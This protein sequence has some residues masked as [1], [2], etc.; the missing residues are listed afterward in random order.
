MEEV[1]TAVQIKTFK[2]SVRLVMDELEALLLKKQADYGHENI[3]DFGELGCLIRS[4]DKISRL[5]N[6]ML[7]KKSPENETLDDSWIDLANYAIIALM[8]RRNIFHKK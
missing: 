2:E 4:N 1:T 3:T 7:K 5:K 6:L 8:L